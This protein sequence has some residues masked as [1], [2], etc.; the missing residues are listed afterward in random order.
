MNGPCYGCQAGRY[1]DVGADLLTKLTH[2]Q[3]AAACASAT[4]YDRA[5]AHEAR[6]A[7][8]EHRDVSWEDEPAPLSDEETW[9]LSQVKQRYA[10]LIAMRRGRS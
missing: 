6:A 7:Y 5:R 8:I 9:N 10:A 4:N 3:I 1:C 2:M